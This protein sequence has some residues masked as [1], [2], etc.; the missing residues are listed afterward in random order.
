[1]QIVIYIPLQSY[2]F[3]AL[4]ALGSNNPLSS[5]TSQN[6]WCP[7]LKCYI[8]LF[9]RSGGKHI[10][11]D[12]CKLERK[13][14]ESLFSEASPLITF[15]FVFLCV[16]ITC[17]HV[18]PRC[19]YTLEWVCSKAAKL[20]YVNQS[21]HHIYLCL[22]SCPLTANSSQ[23]VQQGTDYKTPPLISPCSPFELSP[24]LS[25]HPFCPPANRQS[26]AFS[27]H[28]YLKPSSVAVALCFYVRLCTAARVVKCVHV[29]LYI[30]V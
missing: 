8:V 15:I 7:S 21:L 13:Q 2:L 20:L 5:Y 9:R 14:E 10:K 29:C 1:M 4:L 25:P 18:S 6:W 17:L 22:F 26:L 27:S 30:C 3:L 28:R 23:T 11:I 24:S 12:G 16:I 19:V